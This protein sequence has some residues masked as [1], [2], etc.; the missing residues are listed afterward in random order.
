MTLDDSES[1]PAHDGGQAGLRAEPLAVVAAR[2]TTGDKL[3]GLDISKR[4]IGVAVSDGERRLAVPLCLLTRRQGDAQATTDRL[5]ALI[6]EQRVGGLVVGL[7]LTEGGEA[8]VR[9]RSVRGTMRSLV[10]LGLACP[11]AEWD[12]RHSTRA[13]AR[14]R[15]EAQSLKPEGGTAHRDSI[16]GLTPADKRN[17]DAEA[18]TWILQGALDWLNTAE[19]RN[20]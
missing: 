1:S 11:W 7:P 2:L 13:V 17:S 12:E 5:K 6:E 18:A 9:V 16:R 20:P 3:F 14:T 4:A 19:I 10:L 8:S 15:I